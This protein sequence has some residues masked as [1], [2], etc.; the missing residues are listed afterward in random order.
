M[1]IDNIR[2][3]FNISAAIE[4]CHNE[5][6]VADCPLQSDVVLMT[7]ALYGRMAYG[8]CVKTGFGYIGCSNDVIEHLHE[9]CS[10]RTSCALRIPDARLDATKPCNE[11]LKSYLEAEYICIT[12]EAS[13]TQ[14]YGI[15]KPAQI[16]L[17]Y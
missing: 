16:L 1:R 4:Y 6:F 15:L 17:G 2:F 8:Q 13:W 14:A 3:T 7:S 9:R 5:E 12:G 11:D 10:G